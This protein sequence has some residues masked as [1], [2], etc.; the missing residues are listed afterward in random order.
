MKQ[1]Y[2]YR[3][4]TDS[5]ADKLSGLQLQAQPRSTTNNKK[6]SQTAIVVK[7]SDKQQKYYWCQDGVYATQPVDSHSRKDARLW[8]RMG[9]TWYPANEVRVR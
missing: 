2:P 5:L 3:P 8:V 6:F 4:A 1:R 9:G 7:W